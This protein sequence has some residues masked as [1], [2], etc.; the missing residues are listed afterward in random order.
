MSRVSAVVLGLVA[1][2]AISATGYAAPILFDFNVGSSPTNTGWN[3][4]GSTGGT[5][6]PVSI[7]IAPV[8]GGIW[9]DARERGTALTP[10]GVDNNNIQV[11]AGLLGDMYRDFLFANG[12]NAAGEGMDI[13]VSGLAPS[14]EYDVAVWSYDSG[15]P[16]TRSAT[17]GQSG[18]S[19]VSLGFQGDN[20]SAPGPDP[21]TTQ[22]TDYSATFKMTSDAAGSA[23]IEGRTTAGFGAVHNVF[24]N[25]IAFSEGP[26][27]APS[28]P[29]L[30]IDV[31]STHGGTAIATEAGWTSLDATAGNGSKVSVAGVEFE[32]SSADGSRNRQAPNDLAGDFIYDNGSAQAGILRVRNLPA[33]RWQAEVWAWDQAVPAGD[34]I[35]GIT[36]FADGPEMIFTNSFTMSPTDPFTFT[37]D[38]TDL[39]EGFGIFTRENNSRNESR[40]NA[41]RLTALPA[42]PFP[43]EMRVD[44]DTSQRGAPIDTAAGFVSL[45]AT[46][47]NG[48]WVDANGVMFQVFSANSSVNRQAPNALTSD[49]IYDDGSG[50]AC[51][52]QVFGLPDGIWEASVWAWDNSFPNTV[53]DQIVGITQ[54]PDEM[55][56]TDSF[57]PSPTDPFT[58]RFDSTGLPNGFGIFTRENN[59]WDRSRFNAIQLSY[60]PE[61]TTLALLGLGA[62][63][64]VRRRRK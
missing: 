19:T 2:L 51:G 61:P 16:G 56:F 54:F 12:S 41:L 35:V 23:V 7:A 50:Q 22:Q 58:F 5:S 39:P 31:D 52:V 29:Q 59:V 49:F 17:W 3:S 15:S 13:A 11:P 53:G 37:F 25:G 32:A 36:Q 48:A 33:G 20:G 47:G 4:A 60:I 44:I 9:I 26:L 63:A 46:A 42:L 1:V 6:G 34:Q 55:I 64:L 8:G 27:P 30:Q 38:S 18:G 14:T 28:F 45:D 21:D 10:Q 24:L 40:F 57:A 43:L 62:L